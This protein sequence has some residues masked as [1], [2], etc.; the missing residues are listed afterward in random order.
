MGNIELGTSNSRTECTPMHRNAARST[1]YCTLRQMIPVNTVE[2]TPD[3]LPLRERSP[4]PHNRTR[5][6]NLTLWGFPSRP[7]RPSVK[8]RSLSLVLSIL[9][10][11]DSA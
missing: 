7:L 1:D 5:T 8:I 9:L 6:L 3:Y 2:H 11:R 10:F 4:S